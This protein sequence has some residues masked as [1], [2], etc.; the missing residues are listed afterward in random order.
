MH[1]MQIDS[2]PRTILATTQIR[3]DVCIPPGVSILSGHARVAVCFSCHVMTAVFS[4]RR[5]SSGAW[6]AVA[7]DIT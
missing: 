2:F 5:I 3:E 4:G 1:C 6:P 7:S